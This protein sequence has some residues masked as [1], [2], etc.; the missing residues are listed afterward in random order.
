MG[1][2]ASSS[3]EPAPDHVI[4][5]RSGSGQ[6]L[7][8]RLLRLENV[9]DSD[10]SPFQNGDIVAKL[11]LTVPGGAPIEASSQK[12]SGQG[13]AHFPPVS[14]RSH[15]KWDTMVHFELGAGRT[16]Q[17]LKED[18]ATLVCRIFD[19]DIFT[20]DDLL[21]S[22]ELSGATLHAKANTEEVVAAKVILGTGVKTENGDPCMIYFK[23]YGDV[24]GEP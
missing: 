24:M 22:V 8:L 4:G 9:P 15:V 11:V 13:A 6:S 1:C 12:S 23:V 17:S 19:T 10:L 5:A 2:G 18:G 3:A 14:A 21:G 20:E 7:W 16:W